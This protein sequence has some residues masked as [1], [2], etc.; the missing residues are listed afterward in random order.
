MEIKRAVPHPVFR[1]VVRLL[2][3]RR[4]DLGSTVLRWP[5]PARPQQILDIHLGEPFQVRVGGGPAKSVP[6]MVVVGP[7]TFPRAQLALSG[8]VHVFNILFQPAGL[9]RLTGINMISLVDHDPSASDVLGISAVR[10]G[11]AVR[12]ARDFTARVRAVER[13]L[14]AMISRRS[15]PNGPIDLT[16]GG[17]RWMGQRQRL[18]E[19]WAYSH[20]D[21]W[22]I[23]RFDHVEAFASLGWGTTRLNLMHFWFCAMQGSRLRVCAV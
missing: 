11:D 9:N 15:Q 12:L 4:L 6:E 17:R 14:G 22:P 13:W 8:Q 18:C 1:P 5:V 3:E 16:A 20:A 19:V 2:E 10:L 23:V 7:Q 21:P